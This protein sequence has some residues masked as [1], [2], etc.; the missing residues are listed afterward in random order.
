MTRRSFT[1]RPLVDQATQAAT[2]PDVQQAI[3]QTLLQMTPTAAPQPVPPQHAPAPPMWAYL[4]APGPQVVFVPQRRSAWPLVLLVL[5][6]LVAF[7]YW[8][9][10]P[11]IAVVSTTPTPPPAPTR[12]GQSVGVGA[13]AGPTSAPTQAQPTTP[14]LQPTQAP[15]QPGSRPVEPQP[16]QVIMQIQQP[17]PEPTQAPAPTAT[18]MPPTSTPEPTAMPVPTSTPLPTST[19]TAYCG[20]DGNLYR[21]GKM[22][23]AAMNGGFG[24]GS[25]SGGSWDASTATP[26]GWHGGGGSGW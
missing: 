12:P 3:L 5:A 20:S 16:Q 9:L 1:G 15:P 17:S 24:C 4:Q 8:W 23:N 13:P 22:I 2:S 10:Q 19:P 21:D 6:A 18:P 26:L 14:P 11:S 7:A 25:R